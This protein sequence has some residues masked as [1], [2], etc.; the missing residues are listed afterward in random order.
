MSIEKAVT[1]GLVGNEMSKKITGTNE[2]STGRSSVAVGSG[3]V[4][5]ATAT[6]G[7]VVAGLVSSPIIVPVAVASGLVAGIASLFD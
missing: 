3:T 7:L 6:G 4:L 2:V 1:L 5:G